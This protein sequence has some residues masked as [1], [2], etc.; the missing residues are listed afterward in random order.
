VTDDAPPDRPP[1]WAPCERVEPIVGLTPPPNYDAV[2]RAHVDRNWDRRNL[3]SEKEQRDAIRR[4][5]SMRRVW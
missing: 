1:R 5:R 4:R 2:W 3:P